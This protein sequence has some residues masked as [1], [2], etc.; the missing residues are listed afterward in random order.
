MNIEKIIREEYYNMNSITV[1]HGSTKKFDQFDMTMVGTG[2]DGSLGGWGIYFSDNRAVSMRYFLPK[3]QIKQYRIQSGEYFD[4]DNNIDP[5][6]T[7][8]MYIMLQRLKN[9]SPKDLQEFNETYVSGDNYSATNKNVY[10]WL[11]YILKSEKNA[12]LFLDKL[13]YIGNTMEDRWERNARNYIVFDVE[14]IMSEI[15]SDEEGEVSDEQY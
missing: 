4:L 15:Q 2:D 12:S 3:G 1:W 9:I 11:S 10:D 8:R 5:E 13:N 14:A 6:E 7:N